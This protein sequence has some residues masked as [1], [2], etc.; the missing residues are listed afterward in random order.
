MEQSFSDISLSHSYYFTGLH[1]FHRCS[2][3]M[4]L[5]QSS[6]PLG[7]HFRSRRTPENGN[8]LSVLFVFLSSQWLRSKIHIVQ[9]KYSKLWFLYLVP[10][11]EDHDIISGKII[12][13]HLPG[14]LLN[15]WGTKGFSG[16]IWCTVCTKGFEAF[17]NWHIYILETMCFL[18]S[19][20]HFNY[21]NKT[22][23]CGLSRI[24]AKLFLERLIIN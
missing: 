6:L 13:G 14:Y 12:L 11:V 15:L 16:A 9:L 17:R 22:E 21:Q 4:P 1:D 18:F 2:Y 20:I 23:F 8:V 24:T 10:G 19:L 7:P 5:L 3:Q